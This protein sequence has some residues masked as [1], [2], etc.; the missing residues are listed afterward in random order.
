MKESTIKTSHAKT[1]GRRSAGRAQR[2]P[3]IDPYQAQQKLNE[4][5]TCRQCGAV[6]H[7]GRWQWGEAPTGV[8]KDLCPACRRINDKL[9]AGVI[10]LHGNI[11]PEVKAQI[12][13]LARNVETAEN[14]EHPLNRI[15]GFEETEEGLMI[16]TTDIHLPRR[17]GEAL[18]RAFHG[19][20]EMY[21]DDG[22]YFMRVDWHAPL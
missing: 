5:T 16:S 21:F 20:I 8:H 6:Y 1:P 13:H 19:E 9:P 18:R 12:S 3:V 14:S 15:I 10:A 2:N 17:I 11:A 7:Q 4:P 22:G